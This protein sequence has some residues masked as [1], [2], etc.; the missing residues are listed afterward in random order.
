METTTRRTFITGMAAVAAAAAPIALAQASETTAEEGA[1]VEGYSFYETAS[2]LEVTVSDDENPELPTVVVLATGG[3]IAG[4]GAAGKTTGYSAGQLDVGT[5]VDSAAGILEVAN[6]RGAQVCNVASDNITDAHWIQIASTINELAADDD[7]AGFVVTH[8]TDTLEETAYFLNLTVKTAKPVVLTG[9]MRP[10]TATSAD[11]PMNLYQSIALAANPDAAGRGA[12]VVFSDGIYGGR[13]VQKVNTFKTD[14]FN[15]RDMGCLGYMQDDNAYFYNAT[16]KVHTVDSE[17]DVEGLEGLP[18]VSVAYF[19]VDADPGVFDYFIQSG[20]EGIVIA[21][22]GAGSYSSLWDEAI[23]PLVES[24]VPV[25]DCSRINAGLVSGE[26]GG[27]I[28]GYNLP[29]QKAVVLLRL[30]LTVTTDLD[31][32]QAMFKRY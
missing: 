25:V 13:D 20:A 11:G 6:V 12:M 5:L 7:I 23:A 4:T 30:A 29:P 28:E 21:G 9:A 3:T 16:V 19:T 24:G 1:A 2:G 26:D 8:G 32:I 14:A 27:M 18:S 10:S 22:A 15:G 17:F 31:E